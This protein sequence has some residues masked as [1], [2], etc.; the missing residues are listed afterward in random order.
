MAELPKKQGNG[1]CMFAYNNEQLDYGKF[2]YTCAKFIKRN[3]KN[4]SVALI[5]NTGTF[6]WMVQSQ[7]EKAVAEAFDHI[8]YEEPEEDGKRNMRVHHDS[9]WTEFNAPFSNMNK[10]HVFDVTPFERTLLI[11]TDMVLMNNF[12]DYIFDTDVEVGLHRFAQYIGG[13]IPYMNEVTLNPSGIN[14]WWSTVV[15]FDQSNL[16]KM[17]FDMWNHVRENYEYY[18]LL[19]QF[20]PHLFR[21]DFCVSIACHLMNGLNNENFVHDF[22]GQPLLNMDQKDDIVK[23]NNLDDIVFLKHNRQEPWKNVLIKHSK[24]NIH[25]MNKRAFDRQVEFLKTEFE[26]ATVE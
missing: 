19:Y 2:A 6:D 4:N 24:D 21:T 15:Y 8:I 10:H 25:L 7:G 14:H 26:G 16:S 22:L 3:M 23:F 9:P 17:F 13:E 1:V 12:Y 18:S 5:T 11:D 20:S